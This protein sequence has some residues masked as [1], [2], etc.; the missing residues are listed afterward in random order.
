MALGGQP[1]TRELYPYQED[2]VAF[3]KEHRGGFLLDEPG[4]GKTCQAIQAASSLGRHILIIC[5]NSLKAWWRKEIR[6]ICGRKEAVLVATVGGRFKYDGDGNRL[7]FEMKLVSVNSRNLIPKWTIVHYAGARLQVDEFCKLPWDV[8][9]VD[10][11]HFIKN[12]KTKRSIA[13]KTITPKG[14]IKVGLTATPFSRNPADWWSQLDW[15]APDRHNWQSYWRFYEMFT[16]YTLETGDY[17]QRYRKVNGGK[18]LDLLARVMSA[19]AIRRTKKVVAPQIPPLTEVYMPLELEGRQATI[20]RKLKKAEA[21]AR[22]HD[23]K[24]GETHKVLMVNVLAQLTRLEQSLSHPWTLDGK[25]KGAKLKWFKEWKEGYPHPAVIATKFKESANHLAT[26]LGTRAITGDVGVRTRQ[27]LQEAWERGEQQ[28]LI[29]TIHTIGTGLNLAKAHAIVLY[30]QVYSAI[31]MDQVRQRI[32]RLTTDHPVEAIYLHIQ[33][34]TNDI[35]LKSFRNSWETM[36][37]VR[38]MVEELT[39]ESTNG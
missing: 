38:S 17:D 35:V 22:I 23:S 9:I 39:K 33:K 4:L 24:T 8:V 12:R 13:V 10:E 11:C 18:N 20:Y 7:E 14:A 25:V 34:T 31:L 19:Y 6:A 32:H 3:L 2:G 29:G 5:P 36:E 28:F 30:D 1:M 27:A 26:L 16:D 37:L 21:E 15:I